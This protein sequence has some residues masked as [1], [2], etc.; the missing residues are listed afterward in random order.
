M[1]IW[2]NLPRFQML[3]T[4]CVVWTWRFLT[5]YVICEHPCRFYDMSWIFLPQKILRNI[6][7]PMS[8]W[9]FKMISSISTTVVQTGRMSEPIWT[10]INSWRRNW[11]NFWGSSVF[12]HFLVSLFAITPGFLWI[13][14]NLKEH[15]QPLKLTTNSKRKITGWRR[16]SP[17]G[18]R[19]NFSG[20]FG[21]WKSDAKLL[22]LWSL[23]VAPV[24]RM[25]L[26]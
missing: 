6:Q 3:I 2:Y 19:P 26:W 16:Q 24:L 18:A 8:S 25:V 20:T 12:I 10:I 17:F 4:Q 13:F 21:A 5:L 14:A 9:C 22:A 1:I 7:N 11:S 15:T 23:S